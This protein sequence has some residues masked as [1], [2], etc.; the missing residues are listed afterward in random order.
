MAEKVNLTEAERLLGDLI[1]GLDQAEPVINE[2]YAER[3]IEVPYK[4]QLDAA[5]K[6]FNKVKGTIDKETNPQGPGV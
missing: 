2:C 3:K 4:A 6:Y 5:K 1:K